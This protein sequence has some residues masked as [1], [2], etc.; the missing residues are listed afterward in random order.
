MSRFVSEVLSGAPEYDGVECSD[1]GGNSRCDWFVE[2]VAGADA[3]WNCAVGFESE[4]SGED[5]AWEFEVA[6]VEAGGEV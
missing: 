3:D 4:S 1:D 2:L 6:Q 5:Q